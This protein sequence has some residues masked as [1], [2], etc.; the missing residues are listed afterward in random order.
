MN[1]PAVSRDTTTGVTLIAVLAATRVGHFGGIATP[2]DA[3]LAVFFLLGMWL[4]SP[5]WL[6]LALLSAA[7]ADAL[8]IA[9]GG[10]SYCITPAYPFLVPTYAALWGAGWATHVYVGLRSAPLCGLALTGALLTGVTVAFILSNASFYALS[11]YFQA[12]PAADYVRGVTQYFL[13][14]LETTAVYVVIAIVCRRI[15]LRVAAGRSGP[16]AANR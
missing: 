13:P 9:R 2:H 10:S 3:S 14:Y 7:A 6:A 15:L 4:A 12:M 16:V 8:A 5:R 11:G 1:I